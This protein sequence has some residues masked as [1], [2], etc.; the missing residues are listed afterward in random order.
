MKPKENIT[1]KQ[2][3][4]IFT[5]SI[6]WLSARQVLKD[7]NNIRPFSDYMYMT[8]QIL[9]AFCFEAYLN[10]AGEKMFPFWDDVER[11]PKMNKLNM[12][13]NHLE[14]DMDFGKEPFQSIK[15]LWKFRNYMAHARTV[16]IYDEWTQ[17]KV[18]PIEKELPK[19]DWEKR[20]TKDVTEKTINDVET[21]IRLIHEKANISTGSLGAISTGG[22]KIL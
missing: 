7:E 17:S 10:F 21:V 6:L 19:T 8:A 12:I 3:N 4:T 18:K 22:G 15:L 11:I 20:C 9:I 16:T 14:I 1:I 2:E 13:C 5:H